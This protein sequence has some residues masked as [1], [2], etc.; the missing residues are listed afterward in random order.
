[1]L[2]AL[3]AAQAQSIV[4]AGVGTI[5]YVVQGAVSWRLALVIGLPALVGVVLGW[6]LAQTLGGERMRLALAATLIVIGP[7]LI[8]RN[9]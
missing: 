8:L 9:V 3:A 4:I 6:R 5:G 1:M 7:Y 2:S